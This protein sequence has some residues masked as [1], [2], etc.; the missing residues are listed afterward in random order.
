L[1]KYEN[2]KIKVKII[3]P[4]HGIFEQTPNSHL[5]S[6][7]CNQ[8]SVE[9]KKIKKK[10][11]IDFL[12]KKH[13]NK[14][15]YS[16]VNF[17]NHFSIIKIICPKHGIFEQKLYAH[18]KGNGCP[19]CAQE[20]LSYNLTKTNEQFI[21]D[22]IK[23]HNHTYDY[24]LVNYKNNT[25]KVEIICEKHGSFWQKPNIHLSGSGCPICNYSKGEKIIY[26]YLN[27][28]DILFYTQMKFNGCKDKLSLPFD[29]YLPNYNLCIEYDGQQHF[30]MNEYFGGEK[31]FLLRQK[32][33]EIKNSFCK[34]NDINLLRISYKDDII[35]KLSKFLLRLKPI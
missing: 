7:G 24:S 3:C 26:N 28:K 19:K 18:K 9:K 22:S 16:L 6:H 4:K 23:I 17:D 8:C 20:K 14:Y 15:D 30:I 32:H 31:D 13:N 33:D 12:I 25:T 35:S 21:N 10:E 29:F 5:Q 11:V 27:D 2:D 1:V 34:E